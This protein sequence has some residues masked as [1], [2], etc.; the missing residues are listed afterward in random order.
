MVV[1]DKEEDFVEGILVEKQTDVGPKK[2]MLYSLEV[3]T[4]PFGVWGSA[5]LDSRMLWVNVGDK[6]R[7]TYK[8]LAEAKGGNNPAKI[9]KVEVDKE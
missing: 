8:G 9:F 3:E 1:F 5:I 7:I 4:K 2:S 6:V